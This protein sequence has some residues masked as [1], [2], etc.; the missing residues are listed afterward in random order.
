MV[1]KKITWICFGLL[2]LVQLWTPLSVVLDHESL[3]KNGKPF[4]FLSAPVDPSDPLRGKYIILTFR[5]NFIATDGKSKW[6]SGQEVYVQL[7]NDSGGFAR[8]HSL[9]KNKPSR[10]VDFIHASINY[11]LYDSLNTV[12]IEWPFNRFYMEESKAFDAEQAYIKTAADSTNKTYSLVRVRNGNAILE[13]V[14][15]NDIPIGKYVRQ[16]Q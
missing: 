14:F 2:V 6:E 8:I 3:L 11:V 13:D 16:K 9:H 15:I 5:D 7:V 10:Y 1:N 4:K 12:H